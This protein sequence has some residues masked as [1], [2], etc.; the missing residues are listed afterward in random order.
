MGL[1]LKCPECQASN[2]LSQKACIS[3]GASLQNLPVN[4]RVYVLTPVGSPPPAPT[5]AFPPTEELKPPAM[6]ERRAEAEAKG[7]EA[8]VWEAEGPPPRKPKGP[9]AKKKK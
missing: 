7:P 5:P 6:E 1:W 8:R 4:K 2:P 3:C 9:K